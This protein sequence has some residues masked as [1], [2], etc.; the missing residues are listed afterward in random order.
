MSKSTHAL[1]VTAMPSTLSDSRGQNRRPVAPVLLAALAS[2]AILM[3]VFHMSR[4]AALGR[5]E[6][7][8]EAAARARTLAV[9]SEFAKQRAVAAILADDGEV[10]AALSAPGAETV[11]A[12]SRKLDRVKDETQSSVIYVL[13]GTGTAVAASNWDEPVSFVGES[14]AFRDYFTRALRDGTAQQFAMGTVSHKPGLYLSHSMAGGLGVVVV[15]VEFTSVEASWTGAADETFVTDADGQVLLA[16]NPGWRFKTL[17]PPGADR[18]VTTQHLPSAGWNLTLYT[19]TGP[20]RQAALFAT[21]TAAL[22]LGLLALGAGLVWRGTRRVARRAEADRRYSADLEL[23]VAE[24]TSALSAE[25]NERRAAEQR[26]GA[27]QADL[28][29]ANKLAALGQITAGV[30]HE[31]NQ[32][33]ATIRLLAENALALLPKRGN[34]PPEVAENLATVVRMADR[35]GHITAELRSFSRKATGRTEPV[36]LKE[37]FEASLLLHASRLRSN[38]VRMILP[39]IRPDLAVTGDRI[40]LEQILVNLLQ[41]AH[42]ALAHHPDPEIRVT[43]AETPE[44]VILSIRDNGPGLSPEAA[45][46]LFVPFTTTKP[47]GLGL[48]LVIAHDIARDFGGSLR[49]DAPLPGEGATFHL[50]LRK[51]R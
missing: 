50:E 42:E 22:G 10:I 51:A 30:A 37:A 23:A 18:L 13:D 4:Q 5:I 44:T 36:M 21:G 19:P 48:G 45:A 43:L 20:A 25:M 35:I 27:L 2:L 9:E 38:G 32:P 17:P 11:A 6:V 40:R 31:V 3:S 29:Q 16:G 39:Q 12:I 15:K 34:A 8:A 14:Y 49:A 7:Q 47:N 26:L 33:L 1:R 46:G 28:V 41:N 24:R